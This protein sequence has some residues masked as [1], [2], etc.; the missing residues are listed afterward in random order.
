MKNFKPLALFICFLFISL[1]ARAN[2]SEVSKLKLSQ[3]LRKTLS[4]EMTRTIGL[5]EFHL[6]VDFN[7]NNLKLNKQVGA[8]SSKR[9]QYKTLELPGLYLEGQEEYWEQ[10]PH[11]AAME[12]M[13]LSIDK[14]KL[15]LDYHQDT[16]AEADIRDALYA[17][18]N[19]TIPGLKKTDIQIDVKK[20]LVQKKV[21]QNS[22]VVQGPF[23]KFW[24]TYYAHVLILSLLALTLFYV[25]HGFVLKQGFSSLADILKNKSKTQTS[26]TSASIQN[27]Q[28]VAKAINSSDF[29]SFKSYLEAGKVLKEMSC[30]E[31]AIF[32]EIILLKVM[33]EDFSSIL[34]LMDVFPK[35]QKD[36][37]INNMQPEKKGRFREFI[38]EHGTEFMQDDTM[39]KEEAIKLIKLI[40]LASY[41][42]QDLATV[43]LSD[44]CRGLQR[45]SL[46]K[47][48]LSCDDKEKSILI[49][50]I[51]DDALAFYL[52]D[53]SIDLK[54]VDLEDEDVGHQELLELII[55]GS[56]AMGPRKN[57]AKREKLEQVY[58]QLE[59]NKAEILADTLG[60]HQDLRLESLFDVYKDQGHI[61]LQTLNFEELSS[62]YALLSSGMQKEILSSL[63]ELLSER[64][65]FSKRIVNHESLK[66]KGDFYNYLRSLH[67]ENDKS[68]DISGLKLVA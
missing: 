52:N 65:K 32:E 33:A 1:T 26:S 4:Q 17:I 55:K 27:Q 7:I 40:K 37:F 41:S 38:V 63:P 61:Y 36:S 13:L 46:R 60:I 35:G 22:A 39:M 29:E 49:D 8:E 50:Y 68:P 10:K 25:L 64:L 58:G 42:P 57:L 31:P 15:I 21:G 6:N 34:I 18:V 47:L 56:M 59:T 11:Q 24:N 30:S 23:E 3:Y 48:I 2:Q 44:L 54:Y 66:A 14:I 62:L 19:T 28:Q 5:K 9:G 43:I 20:T 53:G 51:P 67:T 45:S 12:D 16:Y